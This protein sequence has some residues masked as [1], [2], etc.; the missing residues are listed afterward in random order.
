MLKACL[1]NPQFVILSWPR[2]PC[3]GMPELVEKRSSRSLLAIISVGACKLF[4]PSRAPS[5]ICPISRYG[6]G[7]A[8]HCHA[9]KLANGRASLGDSYFL[10]MFRP[11]NPTA[12]EP[13]QQCNINKEDMPSQCSPSICKLPC[14]AI[15]QSRAKSLSVKL[16]N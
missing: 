2:W 12:A 14:Q 13:S 1:E 9:G 15:R 7:L 4:I 16:R 8:R 6:H 11:P 3:I 10:L 5:G